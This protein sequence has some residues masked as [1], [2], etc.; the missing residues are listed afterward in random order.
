MDG[1]IVWAL[2]EWDPEPRSVRVEYCNTLALEKL[3]GRIMFSYYNTKRVAI[4]GK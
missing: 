3:K 1:V 4:C 2:H